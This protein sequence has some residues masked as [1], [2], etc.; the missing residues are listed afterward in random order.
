[1]A[2]AAQRKSGMPYVKRYAWLMVLP[3]KPASDEGA[4]S[5]I[6]VELMD[7]T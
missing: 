6:C 3:C 4:A 5:A 1:M 2:K 7:R